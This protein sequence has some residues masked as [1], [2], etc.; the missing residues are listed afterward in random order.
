MKAK[1]LTSIYSKT[2][3]ISINNTSN[4]YLLGV[5]AEGLPAAAGLRTSGK[6]AFILEIFLR[7]PAQ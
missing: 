2:N 7:R 5:K 4:I 3:I 1:S 6:A